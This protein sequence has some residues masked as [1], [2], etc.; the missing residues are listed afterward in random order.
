MLQIYCC[1]SMYAV[2]CCNTAFKKYVLQRIVI[3]TL[4]N[5]HVPNCMPFYACNQVLSSV[6]QNDQYAAK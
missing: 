2:L 3:A 1:C 5:T 4:N 6:L